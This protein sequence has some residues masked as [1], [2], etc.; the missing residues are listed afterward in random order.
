MEI[1]LGKLIE[2]NATD[3]LQ[4]IANSYDADK[5]DVQLLVKNENV[6]I[7]YGSAWV[8]RL[9]CEVSLAGNHMKSEREDGYFEVLL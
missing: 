8:Y 3:I 6:T 4:I 2:L 9:K 7:G 1:N 5:N